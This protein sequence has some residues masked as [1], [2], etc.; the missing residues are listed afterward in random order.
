MRAGGAQIEMKKSIGSAMSWLARNCG[1]GPYWPSLTSRFIVLNSALAER[2]TT[3]AS[4]VGTP[5]MNVEKKKRCVAC[6]CTRSR[7]LI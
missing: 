5:T 6:V 4:C 3:T 7:V 2:M 1:T